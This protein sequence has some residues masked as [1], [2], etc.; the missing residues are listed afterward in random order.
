MIRLFGSEVKYRF[1]PHLFPFTEPSIEVDVWH[2]NKWIELMGSGMV[3]PGVLRNM[4]V[5]TEQYRGLAFAIGID[6]LAMMKWG[7][8][9]VRLFHAN[10]LAFLRQFRTKS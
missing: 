8:E 3:H 10:K 2:N 7:I 5:D 4:G 1:R 6:R 9:D